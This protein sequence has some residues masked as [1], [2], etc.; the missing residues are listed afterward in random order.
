MSSRFPSREA[1]IFRGRRSPACGTVRRD[2][3]LSLLVAIASFGILLSCSQRLPLTWDEGES[4]DR[5]EKLLAWFRCDDPLSPEAIAE[6]WVFTTQV[7]GHPA[8]YGI[9]IASGKT[10]AKNFSFLLSPKTQFRFGPIFLFSVAMGTVFYQFAR[11]IHPGAGFF[12]VASLLLFPRLFAHAQIAACDSILTSCWILAWCAFL[13][14][15]FEESR[16]G[17]FH[18]RKLLKVLIWGV[19]LGFTLSAKFTGWIA[20]V[21]FFFSLFFLN[22]NA[23]R[24]RVRDFAARFAYFG[25]GIAVALL[26][27]FVMNPPLW[28]ESIKGF[29]EFFLLNI[30]RKGFNISILF[31]GKMYNLDHPLPWFN[32]ILWTFI[33]VPSGFLL[34]MGIGFF[35]PAFHSLPGFFS[36]WKSVAEHELKKESG[37]EPGF[38]FVMLIFLHPFALLLV[39]SFPGTPPHDGVRLFVSAFA[40]L[41]MLTGSGAWILLRSRIGRIGFPYFRTGMILVALIYGIGLFN[42]SWYGPQ[43]LSYYNGWIGGLP[44][45]ARCGMEPTYY[46]DSLDREVLDWI[47]E[48]TAENE[49]LYFSASSPKSLFLLRKWNEL[50]RDFYFRGKKIEKGAKIRYYVLQRRPSGESILDQQLIRNST[51]VF[52][53]VIRKGGYGIWNLSEVSLLEIYDFEE[54]LKTVRL[55]KA[56]K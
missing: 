48:N 29:R 7:E 40:F 46:W 16:K 26:V 13:C 43:W 8:G 10:V 23:S 37:K 14:A 45:A 38:R 1:R 55:L 12:A 30:S 54:Y 9:V 50:E 56:G 20:V 28:F 41:A 49:L 25:L 24:S 19:F 33:T 39:R 27:F 47:R 52:R 42:M 6:H 36:P 44:G 35:V 31:F 3:L 53:K 51:P 5:A 11:R 4:I 18:F 2:F 22:K 32:T 21:P 15:F 17:L 34:L